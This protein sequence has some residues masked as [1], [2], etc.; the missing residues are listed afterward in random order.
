MVSP[1]R[2]ISTPILED[3]EIEAVNNVLR[4]G[5][6]TQGPKVKEFEEAF[7]SYMGTKYAIATNS[8]TAALHTALL[9][10]GIGKGDEVITTPFSF[11]STANAILFCGA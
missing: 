3:D 6:L 7:A 11:I 8:G 10:S 5:M 9:A 2:R 4:S 1:L